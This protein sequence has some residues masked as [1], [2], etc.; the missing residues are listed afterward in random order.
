MPHAGSPR[1]GGRRGNRDRGL[2]G[3]E[4]SD[5]SPSGELLPG[6]TSAS[7]VG[8]AS[9]ASAFVLGLRNPTNA[10]A[11]GRSESWSRTCP[12]AATSRS[13]SFIPRPSPRP[14]RRAAE[15]HPRRRAPCSSRLAMRADPARSLRR[16]ST[17]LGSLSPTPGR[18][19]TTGIP[20]SILV[21]SRSEHVNQYTPEHPVH[22]RLAAIE[23][24]PSPTPRIVANWSAPLLCA[25]R[26]M[27]P[28]D[29]LSSP[30]SGGCR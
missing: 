21:G 17:L 9:R 4:N 10:P 14:R 15:N 6:A 27:S 5:T 11:I 16:R 2:S 26:I 28:L 1:R 20:K 30:A 8:L 24:A 19:K 25:T 22:A 13:A 3:L 29:V 12:C 23:R 18:S 7:A